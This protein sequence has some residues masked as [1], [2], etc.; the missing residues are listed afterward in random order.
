MVSEDGGLKL[1]NLRLNEL[2]QAKKV[3]VD[4]ENTKIVGGAGKPTEIE[5]RAKDL[6]EE[7]TIT[8]SDYDREKIQDRL[9]NLTR[10]VAV[11]NVGAATKSEIEEKK[12]WVFA[13]LQATLA[14]VEEGVLPG[15]GVALLRSVAMLDELKLDEEEALGAD[16]VRRALEAPI[17]QIAQNAGYDGTAIVARI[18]QSNDENFG[19]NARS[20]EFEDL[21]KEG[22]IDSAKV[23]RI[24][25]QNAASIAGSMLSADRLIL[26]EDNRSIESI[27]G[28][29]FE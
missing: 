1:E 22:I 27:P 21:V 9:A 16:I 13:A 29:A 7:L 5:R 12:T 8:A 6:R 14:A 26:K 15:G 28:E 3:I 19:F 10:S 11:I 23:T 18:R 17:R 4:Q 25:L 20:G 24:A 2:G